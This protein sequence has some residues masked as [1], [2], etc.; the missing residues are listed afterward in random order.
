M[1]DVYDRAQEQDAMFLRHALEAQRRKAG[2]ASGLV[3]SWEHTSATECQDPNCDEPIP[4]ARRRAV[5]GVQTCISCQQRDEAV[6]A[7]K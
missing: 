4:E 5:P 6:K 3:Q 2:A 1:T 7:K